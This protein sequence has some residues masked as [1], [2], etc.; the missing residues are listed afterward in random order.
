MPYTEDEISEI[1]NS[2]AKEEKLKIFTPLEKKTSTNNL[3]RI[4]ENNKN[5]EFHSMVP[6]ANPSNLN[7]D[8]VRFCENLFNKLFKV[9]KIKKYLD[10]CPKTLFAKA[11]SS[12][13]EH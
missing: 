3:G 4:I 11:F 9:S 8:M 7:A 1:R 5:K 2:Q 12:W 6:S 13:S 10:T